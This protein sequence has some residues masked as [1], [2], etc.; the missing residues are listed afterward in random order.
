MTAK[1]YAAKLLSFCDRSEKEIRERILKKGY[2]DEECEE[3]IAFCREYGYIDDM[4]YAMHYVHDA[5]EIRKHAAAR[6]RMELRQKGV[7]EECIEEALEA[8]TDELG[9]L[10]HEMQRRFGNLD[11][12]DPKVKSKV[13]GYFARRGFKSR[14]I[15]RAME[16]EIE[17]DEYE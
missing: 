7:G 4:R 13:Y 12:S 11:F 15:V 2:S 8:I 9:M 16:E 5:V 10:V 1:D 14:D 6:I 3:A 17:F